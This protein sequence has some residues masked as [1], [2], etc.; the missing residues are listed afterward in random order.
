LIII[1]IIIIILVIV[2]QLSDV[3]PAGYGSKTVVMLQ[4]WNKA[5]VGGEHLACIYSIGICTEIIT[6]LGAFLNAVSTCSAFI[7]K[8]MTTND[9]C[10]P[11]IIVTVGREMQSST[12]G[13]D[14]NT[15]QLS[16]DLPLPK[17]LVWFYQ[18]LQ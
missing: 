12:V 10:S 8:G 9:I 4:K 18:N 15:M 13:W 11:A 14:W 17:I 6:R 5:N 2:I 3:G 1:I 7:D 16:L